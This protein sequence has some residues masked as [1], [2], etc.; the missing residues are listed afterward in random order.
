MRPS[1]KTCSPL[2]VCYLLMFRRHKI[3]CRTQRPVFEFGGK[4][5]YRT[6]WKLRSA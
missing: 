3:M 4:I 5:F 2:R 1:V 6:T